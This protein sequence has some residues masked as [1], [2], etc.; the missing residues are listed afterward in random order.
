VVRARA[1]DVDDVGVVAAYC[2]EDTANREGVRLTWGVV[3]GISAG[4][5]ELA[6]LS[7]AEEGAVGGSSSL[8]GEKGDCGAR[9]CCHCRRS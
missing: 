2:G 1:G 4:L 3:T 5:S 7:W 8:M 9:D 6:D